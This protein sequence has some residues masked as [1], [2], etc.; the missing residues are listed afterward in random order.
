[1]ELAEGP[2]CIAGPRGAAGP[3]PAPK[4]A[5][6]GAAAPAGVA[7]PARSPR[8]RPPRTSTLPAPPS[9]SRSGARGAQDAIYRT[10]WRRSPRRLAG[11]QGAPSASRPRNV[12]QVCL[13]PAVRLRDGR[14]AKL[15]F[16]GAFDLDVHV[17]CKKE[18]L[19]GVLA[20]ARTLGEYCRRLPDVARVARLATTSPP[21]ARRA[22][23]YDAED[24][25]QWELRR[26]RARA[27]FP[28]D[29]K[30]ASRSAGTR[31]VPGM[32][33]KRRS[34]WRGADAPRGR[35][36]PWMERKL[37]PASPAPCSRR[38]PWT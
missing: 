8:C 20:E 30:R 14:A 6:D 32:V 15:A 38:G 27:R 9:L 34:S 29:W 7:P 33:D 10:S 28:G 19:C 5:R 13:Q 3:V 36:E 37:G 31:A 23:L 12:A 2:L 26:A 18:Y 24:L 17:E 22:R 11:V 21:P 16:L 35:R 4:R 1:M 25:R